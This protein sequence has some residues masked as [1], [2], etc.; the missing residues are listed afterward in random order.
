MLAGIFQ[1]LGAERINVEDFEMEHLSTDRGG[2]LT[3]IVAGEAEAERAA[4][5]ARGAGL[6]R[7]R[8]ARDR[9]MRVEP[10]TRLVG[11]IAVPGDKSISHRAVL[12]GAL[13]DGETRVT[14]FGRSAD[15]E[16]TIEAVR[17]LGV[18]VYEHDHD[19]LRVFG[20]GLRGLVS[21]G[22]P[23]DC[24]NAGTLVRLLA[25]IL[26]GQ[27]GQQF[28]L[29]GD[30][31]LSA[32]PMKRVT[33]PLAR[34]GA[35]VETDDGHLPLGIDG[36]P[37]RSITYELPVASAQ[38]KSAILLAGLYAK[39][40]TTVVE[41]V[42]D[43]RPHR[44]DAR[45]GRRHDH[46]ARERASRCSRPSGS[47]WA[48][49]RCPG[50]FSSAAPFIVA[51]TLRP[52][53]GAP[54]PRRQPQ[55]TSHRAARRS[56]SGWAG[57]SP[58]TTGAASAVS[59]RATSTC[60]RR[61][62]S[63]RPCSAPEVPLAIDELPLFALAASCAHGNSRLRGAE[64]LRAKESDRVEATVDALRA[65]GQHVIA[66]EDGF[67]IRGVPTRPRG[68][69]IE[70]RGDHRIAMLGAIAALASADGVEIEDAECVAVSFPGFFELLDSAPHERLRRMIVAID[71]PAGAGKSSV[72]RAP[73]GAARLPL[74][75]HR[76]DVPRA[77]L[78]RA[79]RR[80][81]PS[82]T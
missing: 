6:R 73:R 9:R 30:A 79:A 42:A 27:N 21:P 80:A 54:H 65:L 1:A 56:S 14:G 18:T 50:D 2:T 75:R 22:R 29:T 40:E 13:C 35:G 74:P 64:E 32:R 24:A 5:A 10:L 11:H 51:A 33:E 4:D 44:A 82:T 17:A 26:A 68:G 81:S 37:L 20:K 31:S 76:R 23:I 38:V 67:R 53:L 43:A 34:M 71:G 25:G 61:S 69:R 49:S 48:R 16:A 78:A 36:R 52:G 70:S 12:L 66:T 77:H 47:S 7:R 46:A 45:G 28:E 41:P 63:R 58:S 19:T 15:T 3:V 62:S 55:P 59:P 57:A 8:R 60:A 39:G 72:A